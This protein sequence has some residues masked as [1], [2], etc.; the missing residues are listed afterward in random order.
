MVK[1][2]I[3]VYQDTDYQT[4]RDMYVAGV[5]QHFPRA[6]RHVLK[7]PWIQ[8]SLVLSF[9]L[10]LVLSGSLLLSLTAMLILLSVGR[11]L[12]R[13]LWS[14]IIDQNLMQDLL[15]I[16]SSYMERPGCC[17]WVAESDGVVVGT[18]AAAP[19]NTSP[20][21]VELKRMNVCQE[22]RGQG[23]AKALCL[24]VLGFA[25][26]SGFAGIVLGTSVIQTEARSLYH[27][28]GYRLVG[29]VLMPHFLAKF[30]NYTFHK[31]QYHIPVGPQ[32][33]PEQA[34]PDRAL[35]EWAL[36]ERA[37]PERALP[38]RALPE[39]AHPDWAHPE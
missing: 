24:T 34:L 39:Q 35:P 19:S 22:Y 30:T 32:A 17:F 16:R 12:I 15:D 28:M 26:R 37:L 23:I 7:Q 33:L 29:T 13:H 21:D 4:V 2:R 14:S 38:E 25:Q 9:C 3:R 27:K 36:P 20:M 18:V 11:W 6:C 31:Y 8:A 10:L 5:Q 1:Y